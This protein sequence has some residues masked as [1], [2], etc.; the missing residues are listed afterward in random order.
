MVAAM[1]LWVS[2]WVWVLSAVSFGGLA[3]MGCGGVEPAAASGARRATTSDVRASQLHLP[4]LPPLAKSALTAAERALVDEAMRLARE[5]LGLREEMSLEAYAAYAQE[6]VQ[7]WATSRRSLLERLVAEA[8]PDARAEVASA[9]ALS[10][11]WSLQ[12]QLL[13]IPLPSA[14]AGDEELGAIFHDAL[15]ELA[16]GLVRIALRGADRCTSA[17]AVPWTGEACRSLA[18]RLSTD[19]GA[20]TP[21]RAAA[22][23]VPEPQHGVITTR[24]GV[25]F[26]DYSSPAPRAVAWPSVCDGAAE[27][28]ASSVPT[29]TVFAVSSPSEL[30]AQL[31]DAQREELRLAIATRLATLTGWQSLPAEDVRR[32]AQAR[33]ESLDAGACTLSSSERP[34]LVRGRGPIYLVRPRV[35][36]GGRAPGTCSLSV[37][38]SALDADGRTVAAR[39]PTFPSQ[40]VGAPSTWVAAAR[41]LEMRPAEAPMGVLRSSRTAPPGV[42][43]YAYGPT[44]GDDV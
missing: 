7:P 4:G 36:C 8:P 29:A 41:S 33:A 34:E 38:L 11:A 22:A 21:P 13:A 40:P 20:D 31:P 15:R 37:D 5:P 26:N 14:I 23:S 27:S 2:A 24:A 3:G 17:S 6:S 12:Q 35:Q 19:A 10:L 1:R 32:A 28:R 42:S 30:A 9:I 44:I 16:V 39:L 18:A 43:V 25:Y